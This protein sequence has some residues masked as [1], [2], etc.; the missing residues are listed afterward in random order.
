LA[1]PCWKTSR[2]AA[3]LR[4]DA[5]IEAS[6]GGQREQEFELEARRIVGHLDA[7]AVEAGNRGDQTEA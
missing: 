7:G 5:V 4:R 6:P 3:S 1:T 2:L